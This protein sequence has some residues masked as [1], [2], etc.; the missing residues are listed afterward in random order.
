MPSSATGALARL[1]VARAAA[2]G[3]EVQLLL[4][5]AGLS[6]RQIKN[7]HARI[8]AA[9][10]AEL[11]GLL[12]EALGD[13]LFGFHLGQ[14]FDLGEIGLL[15]YVMASAPTLRDA[16]ARA[17]RYGAITNEGIAPICGQGGEVR[18][19]LSYVG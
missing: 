4:C 13:N 14:S 6:E 12:A 8:G 10:Q 18:I 1:A 17:E 7:P 3:V 15:Y 16:L 9:N 11:V 19:R 2:S 5:R